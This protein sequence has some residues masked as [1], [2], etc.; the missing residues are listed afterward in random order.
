VLLSEELSDQDLGDFKSKLTLVMLDRPLSDEGIA[1]TPEKLSADKFV[2]KEPKY[3][4]QEGVSANRNYA[5][6]H[7]VA[8]ITRQSLETAVAS[9]PKGK[10]LVM[11]PFD[12]YGGLEKMDWKVHPLI[13]TVFMG[14]AQLFEARSP[15]YHNLMQGRATET[16]PGS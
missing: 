10:V 16:T 3:D 2:H 15:N 13:T 11:V 8:L 5:M 4:D 14:M 12:A 7:E 6:G 1:L 9:L